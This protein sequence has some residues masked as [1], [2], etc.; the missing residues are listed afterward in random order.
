MVRNKTRKEPAVDQP[1]VISSTCRKLINIKNTDYPQDMPKD[2]VVFSEADRKAFYDLNYHWRARDFEKILGDGKDK[3]F[4][5][6][7]LTNVCNELECIID[8][9]EY[10]D[11][12]DKRDDVE[13]ELDKVFLGGNHSKYFGMYDKILSYWDKV[14]ALQKQ[15]VITIKRS[16]NRKSLKMNNDVLP[17]FILMILNIRDGSLINRCRKRL[18]NNKEDDL[19]KLE[20]ACLMD[21][22]KNM[23]LVNQAFSSF[24]DDIDLLY[25]KGIK[26]IQE[27]KALLLQT[28][29]TRDRIK[30]DI[31]DFITE[32]EA[33]LAR[34]ILSEMRVALNK[35]TKFMQADYDIIIT[36]DFIKG[37]HDL[38][39][40]KVAF[41]YHCIN[42]WYIRKYHEYET[43]YIE[44]MD[45]AIIRD[46]FAYAYDKIKVLFPFKDGEDFIVKSDIT[47]E[48]KKNVIVALEKLEAALLI[49][50]K[51]K[52]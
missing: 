38:V 9:P 39:R 35:V 5:N 16:Y 13:D 49:S 14:M 48:I 28:N 31:R 19:N 2:G 44:K 15:S 33:N 36:D 43:D 17:G 51:Q 26:A 20:I 25:Y 24:L 21:L 46:R 42:S 37:E 34:D 3:K 11:V 50:T 30:D 23:W 40:L 41:V 10:C 27:K 6:L 52:H 45:N 29:R 22:S 18:M 12:D 4:E 32:I 1:Y 47:E 8:Y 7:N